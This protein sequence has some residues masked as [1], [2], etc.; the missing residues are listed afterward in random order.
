[1]SIREIDISV[2]VNPDQAVTRDR[3][4]YCPMAKCFKDGD[5]YIAWCDSNT[6]NRPAW[7]NHEHCAVKKVSTGGAL[8]FHYAITVSDAVISQLQD[9]LDENGIAFNLRWASGVWS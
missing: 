8:G 4:H 3:L 2:R 5:R 6:A 7:V 9:L 1:M